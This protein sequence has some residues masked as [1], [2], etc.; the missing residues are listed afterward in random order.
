VG[1]FTVVGAFDLRQLEVRDYSI[2]R[3]ELVAGSGGPV[4]Q[5]LDAIYAEDLDLLNAWCRA[6]ELAR[7]FGALELRSVHRDH[8][9]LR[10]LY[11]SQYDLVLA[12]PE[13]IES[14]GQAARE[15]IDYQLIAKYPDYG[16][17]LVSLQ[18]M[19]ELN[20]VWM[21]GKT[22]GLLDD[23]N[24]VSSYQI[25]RAALHRSGLDD[26]PKIR[27]FRSH[28]EMYKALFEREVDVIPALLSKEGSDSVLQLPPGL[29]LEETIPGPAWYL[30]RE[31]TQGSV[32]CDLLA[33]LVTSSTHAKVDYFRDMQVVRPCNA[34]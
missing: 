31:L 32:Y 25:P 9:D 17:Q 22:L 26:V 12:K 14:L 4:L 7:H 29:V 34:H 8:L 3:C 23:P 21:K 30:R 15:G 33:T 10:V 1:W 6:P 11:E 28:R 5:I 27:Y 16:S 20:V 2:R 18:G 13:L 19:P 24:S